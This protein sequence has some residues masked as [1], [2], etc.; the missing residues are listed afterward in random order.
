MTDPF[1]FDQLPKFG[2]VGLYELFEFLLSYL[3]MKLSYSMSDIFTIAIFYQLPKFR[4]LPL[5]GI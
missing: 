1:N 2:G 3:T 5:S 4:V